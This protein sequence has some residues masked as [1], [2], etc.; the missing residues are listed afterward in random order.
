MSD[1]KPFFDPVDTKINFTEAEIELLHDWEKNNI[2]EKYLHKNV[3][4]TKTF[5]FLDGPIT[6][7]CSPCLGKDLQGSLAKV[8]QYAG[9]QGEIPEWF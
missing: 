9:F 7:G 8:L 4:S 1:K 6:H 5:S 3:K 2:L